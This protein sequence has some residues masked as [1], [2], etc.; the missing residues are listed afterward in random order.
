PRG[1]SQ[2]DTL[3]QVDI[4]LVRLADGADLSNVRDALRRGLPEDVAVLTRDELA[5]MEKEFWRKSTPIGFIFGL[6]TALGFLVGVIICYQIPAT[7]VADHLPEYATLKAIGY[8]DRFLTGVVMREAFWMSVL[9][10]LPGLAVSAL[11]YAFLVEA[12][13]LPM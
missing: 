7:D 10:F 2:Q 11:L 9:G 13:G 8:S 1:P 6:G 5:D 3:D 4:G 12:T